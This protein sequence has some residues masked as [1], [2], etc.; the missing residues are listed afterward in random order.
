MRFGVSLSFGWTR[1]E[2]AAVLTITELKSMKRETVKLPL[3]SVSLV[4]DLQTIHVPKWQKISRSSRR[5]T[6]ITVCS[7]WPR[8]ARK[9]CERENKCVIWR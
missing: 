9:T 5:R 8:V 7:T 2:N 4:C 6:Y 1:L 3:F